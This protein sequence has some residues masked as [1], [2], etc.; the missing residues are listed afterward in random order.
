MGNFLKI[1]NSQQNFET[2]KALDKAGDFD[3]N[4]GEVVEAEFNNELS[5]TV[6]HLIA[7]PIGAIPLSSS[8]EVDQYILWEATANQLVV[9][10]QANVTGTMKFLVF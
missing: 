9:T 7:Q 6:S 4:S 8:L 3:V 1:G 2:D 10:V 5:V